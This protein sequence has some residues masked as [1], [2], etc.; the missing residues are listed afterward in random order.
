MI[1]LERRLDYPRWLTFVV[2]VL[3]LIL[4][5]II[6]GIVLVATGH[7]PFTTYHQMYDAA[8]TAHGG[9]SSTFVYAT[10]MLFAGLAAAIAFRMR[11]WNIGGEGQIYMGAVGAA[12]V[13]LALGSWPRPLLIAMMMAG[14]VACGLVFALIPGILRAYFR[15]N[16]ILVSLMLN[17]AAGY[18][19]YRG[20]K[21]HAAAKK[22][23]KLRGI[24]AAS[25]G[26]THATC[27]QATVGQLSAYAN[28][29]GHQELDL[30]SIG[31]SR[32]ADIVET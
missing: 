17:Y 11:V 25:M 10:P 24:A 15:T 19:I 27:R 5:A 26:Q 22:S 14:G 12:G 20:T 31:M 3:S 1:K 29:R 32:H 23:V 9:L 2:P 13:G 7:D 21:H 18:F 28:Q 30:I 6:T 16:E 4:A 8:I